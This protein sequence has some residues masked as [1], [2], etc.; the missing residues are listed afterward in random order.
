M[1]TFWG[2]VVPNLGDKLGRCKARTPDG[3]WLSNARLQACND[4]EGTV[5][6]APEYLA[7]LRTIPAGDVSDA[8]TGSLQLVGAGNSRVRLF[9]QRG[10]TW[11]YVTDR[12][13]LT[14]TELRAGLQ[15]GWTGGTSSRRTG[16]AGSPSGSPSP[17]A[18]APPRTR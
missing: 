6:R 2:G 7:P 17:T 12:I 5:V 8:A 4:A 3:R 16:A 11:T 15:L 10:G 9:L 14:A 18:D 1:V 13:R